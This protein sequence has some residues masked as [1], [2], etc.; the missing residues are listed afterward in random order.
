MKQKQ[1]CFERHK[2]NSCDRVTLDSSVTVVAF[3]LFESPQDFGIKRDIKRC[4]RI[5]FNQVIKPL[6]HS[7][8]YRPKAL[9]MLTYIHFSY[10]HCAS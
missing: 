6:F 8:A 1:N 3:S 2:Q 10:F 9:L 5:Y 7:L 4:F